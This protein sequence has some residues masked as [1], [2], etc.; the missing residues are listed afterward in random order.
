MKL[1]YH[2][3]IPAIGIILNIILT[4]IFLK[5]KNN[6][7]HQKFFN[8]LIFIYCWY[9]Q[10]LGFYIAPNEKFVDIWAK[11]FMVGMICGPVVI[12]DFIL[13]FIQL[14]NKSRRIIISCLWV[15]SFFY[16]IINIIGHFSDGYRIY[17]NIK[18]VLIPNWYYKSF[19]IYFGFIIGILCPAALVIKYIK[20][21]SYK[22]RTQILYFFLAYLVSLLIA[23]TNFLSNLGFNIYPLGSLAVIPFVTIITYAI[24]K[25]E[26]L[27]I[28][29]ILKKTLVFTILTSIIT[30]I[31]A[32]ILGGI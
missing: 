9:F 15:I 30:A 31:Y 12:F 23:S 24:L 4:Y 21:H 26:L 17:K 25:H 27:D 6:N 28:K 14:N 2:A 16:I 11:V 22:F 3:I 32:V 13:T 18:Y 10:M 20:T 8:F 19:I 1:N 5:H 29:I 7:L